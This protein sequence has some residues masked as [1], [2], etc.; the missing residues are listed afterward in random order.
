MT[1]PPSTRLFFERSAEIVAPDLIGCYLF[2]A[3]DDK[4]VGGMIIETEAYDQTDP[5]AHC[6]V[7][8]DANSFNKKRT[9]AF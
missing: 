4:R 2:T 6:Y 1:R 5:F 8:A 7:G 9:D 3:I